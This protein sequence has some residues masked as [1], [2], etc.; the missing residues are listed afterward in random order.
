MLGKL[1]TFSVSMSPAV[2]RAT[3]PASCLYLF[4]AW[5]GSARLHI[6]CTRQGDSLGLYG[7][8]D[9]AHRP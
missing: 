4:R 6:D 5:A 1:L 8:R 9:L 7:M 3:V 2:D